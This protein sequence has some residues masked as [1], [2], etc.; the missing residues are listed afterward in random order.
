MKAQLFNDGNKRTGIIFAN[1]YLISNESGLLIVPEKEV[2]LFKDKL[3]KY[4]E[5]DLSDDLEIFLRKKCWHSY[6]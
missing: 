2:N 1:H 6:S 3:V 4:Y 5:G